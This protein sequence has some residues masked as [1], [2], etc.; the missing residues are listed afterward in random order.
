MLVV[1]LFRLVTRRLRI[2]KVVR[3]FLSVSNCIGWMKIREYLRCSALFES[4][5][6]SSPDQYSTWTNSRYNQWSKQTPANINNIFVYSTSSWPE[7]LLH[8]NKNLSSMWL[9]FFY[10]IVSKNISYRELR[11]D[12]VRFVATKRLISWSGMITAPRRITHQHVQI[13]I[14]FLTTFAR[15]IRLLSTPGWR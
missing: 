1:N 12:Q 2:H 3:F 6:S 13:D 15:L 11:G 10:V 4:R 9:L 5:P 7:Y 8:V 14:W